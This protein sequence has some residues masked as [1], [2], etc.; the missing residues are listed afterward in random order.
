MGNEL[1]VPDAMGRALLNRNGFNPEQVAL[2]KRT[3]CADANDDEL[4]LFLAVCQKRQLDPFAKQ[5]YAV[6]RYDKRANRKVMGIQTS[7]DGFRLVAERNGNYAG[8]LGPLWCGADGKWVDIWL[9]TKPPAAAKV[10]VLRND[11]KEPLWS[12]AK[13]VDYVQDSP[14]WGR[15]GA[16]MLAKCA[17][18]L[19]LRRAFPQELGGLYTEDEMAQADAPAND[20]TPPPPAE[21]RLAHD[22]EYTEATDVIDPASGEVVGSRPKLTS[23][24]NALIHVLLE[25]LGTLMDKTTAGKVDG[26]GGKV[27]EKGKNIARGKYTKLLQDKFG[28]T[29][30]DQLTIDEANVVIDRL[31][32]NV[33]KYAAEFPK[34]RV[35]DA[36][37]IGEPVTI[38][39]PTPA[40]ELVD[41]V[42]AKIQEAFPG[43]TVAKE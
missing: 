41:G 40:A 1:V 7:I 15:M 20:Y 22:N 28:K 14:L 32:A 42:M 19:S 18:S 16:H 31:Q 21:E 25:K 29:N 9:D 10:A 27:I 35:N 26:K 12:V 23:K 43:A 4:A 37:V 33:D 13:W 6:F 38:P 39:G 17:E 8:Q 36:A 34:M 24:Q 11:F 2:I 5:I 30:T 3:I